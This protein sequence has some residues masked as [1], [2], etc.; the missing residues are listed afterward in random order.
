MEKEKKKKGPSSGNFLG[1]NF[2]REKSREKKKKFFYMEKD[3]PEEKGRGGHF[4]PFRGQESRRTTRL[5]GKE[6]R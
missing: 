5:T 3:S 4:L 2:S 6:K 1:P